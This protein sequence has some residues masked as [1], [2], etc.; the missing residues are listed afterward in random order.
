MVVVVRTPAYVFTF[1]H[2]AQIMRS[3]RGHHL[4]AVC[5]SRASESG[6]GSEGRSRVC[7]IVVIPV[8]MFLLSLVLV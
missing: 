8:V 5:V 3:I 2:V 1:L 7:G 4:V 6:N